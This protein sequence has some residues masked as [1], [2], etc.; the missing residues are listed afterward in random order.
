MAVALAITGLLEYFNNE[1]I[2]IL[3]FIAYTILS[4]FLPQF[5]FFLPLISYDL[6]RTKNQMVT[7]LALIPYA[8]HFNEFTPGTIWV[9]IVIYIMV[10]LL[11]IRAVKKIN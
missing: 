2:A 3:I 6:L 1:K 4:A 9:L 5:V 8:L 7:L 10:Y 11:K